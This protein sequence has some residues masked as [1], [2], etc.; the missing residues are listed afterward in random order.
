MCSKAPWEGMIFRC[1]LSNTAVVLE[2][3][4][5]THYH[6]LT[7]KLK[8]DSKLS[9]PQPNLIHTRHILQYA[10]SSKIIK[11]KRQY[12]LLHSGKQKLFHKLLL[13]WKCFISHSLYKVFNIHIFNLEILQSS[14]FRALT[15]WASLIFWESHLP[16]V[17]VS[18]DTVPSDEAQAKTRPNSCG[19]HW[20][21]FTENNMKNIIAN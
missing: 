21:E 3:S 4:C 6:T 8:A 5:E 11:Q 18:T 1:L 14:S 20:T 2:L 7:I 16:S 17:C 13:F 15:A 10:L 9:Y 19:A 12:S